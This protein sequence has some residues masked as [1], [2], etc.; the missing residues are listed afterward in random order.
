MT[1]Q[2]FSMKNKPLRHAFRI[3]LKD[4]MVPGIR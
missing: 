2:A 1:L 4:G 3:A